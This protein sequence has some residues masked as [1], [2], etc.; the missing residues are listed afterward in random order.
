MT[1][2]AHEIAVLVALKEKLEAAG[3]PWTPG[4]CTPQWQRTT[5]N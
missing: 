3:A 4:R 1:R 2:I 5:G